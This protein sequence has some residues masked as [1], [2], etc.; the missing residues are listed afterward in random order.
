MCDTKSWEN[1]LKQEKFLTKFVTT[2]YKGTESENLKKPEEKP[3][4]KVYKIPPEVDF[5]CLE[6]WSVW[7]EMQN[8]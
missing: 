2:L 1:L 8:S 6:T 4:K 3:D 5:K 7:A